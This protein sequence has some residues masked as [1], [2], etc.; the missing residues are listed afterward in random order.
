MLD[1]DVC[2]EALKARDARFDGR[3]FVAVTT[4]GIYCRPVCPASL[5]QRKN[6]RFF[7]S[8]A[9]AQE[10]GFRPCLRCRP[11]TAP[12][13]GAW[14]G[15]SNTV[16]R[17][18][19]LIAEGELDGEATSVE[20]LAERLG[21]GGRQLRRL[22][23]EHLGASPVAV[24]Q[25]RRVLFAKQLIHETAL[26]MA[27]VALASGF[28]SVRRFNETFQALYSRPPSAL[29][30]KSAAGASA[31]A[32]GV[33]VR[34]RYRPP[35]D[36]ERM[37]AF[38]AERAVEGVES[39]VSGVYRRALWHD[40]SAG[41]VEIAHAAKEQSLVATI[42]FPSVRA[43]PGV[44]NRIRRAFDLGADVTTIGAHLGRDPWL[45]PLVRARPGLRS[46]GA[47]DGF[48]L[49]LRAVLGQ[50]VSLAAARKLA[51]TLVALCGRA[52]PREVRG[53]TGLTLAFP[54]PGDVV[55]NGLGRL[56]MPSKR[57]A[58]LMALAA[59]SLADPLLFQP[60][61]TIEQTVERLVAVP[62]VGE[63]TAHYIALRAAR[64]PDAFPASDLALLRGAESRARARPKSSELAERAERW[65]PFR[66]YAAEHL[67]AADAA[68]R[69]N[70]GESA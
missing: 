20:T 3:L 60:L 4:T 58:T 53:E 48:E 43:L 21:V 22:F 54:T 19:E 10:A 50:Q 64:D 37:L 69:K 38:W 30:R 44:V 61:A 24:A 34:L 18:L 66:A 32:S 8:A 70:L 40:E 17:G 65:R 67:W 31:R 25:T 29:R 47:W 42:R 56:G 33:T 11:E 15:T 46:P 39:V 52:V 27:E 28:G 62:G 36:W 13:H 49:A 57:R 9:A 26:P 35:Y 2:Y 16:S 5:A 6:C 45:G 51:G 68:R 1:P 12:E 59:A 63:W 23:H 7:V 55:A 14:R 41:T